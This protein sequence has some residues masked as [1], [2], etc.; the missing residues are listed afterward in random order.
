MDT[1]KQITYWATDAARQCGAPIEDTTTFALQLLAW[2]RISESDERAQDGKLYGTYK[3]SLDASPRECFDALINA[4]GEMGSQD[5]A[6][7]L[8]PSAWAHP[9]LQQLMIKLGS[10]PLEDFGNSHLLASACAQLGNSRWEHNTPAEVVS[11][12]SLLAGDLSQKA[13]YCPFDESLQ[14][15]TACEQQGADVFCELTRITPL[16]AVLV[17]LCNSTFE[18]RFGNPILQPNYREAHGLKKFNAAV[19][20]PPWG[21]S[22]AQHH[23]NDPFR[24]FQGDE[25]TIEHQVLRHLLA[26]VDGLIVMIVPPNFLF[27]TQMGLRNIRKELV[28]TKQLNAVITLPTGLFQNT[29]VASSIL[30]INTRGGCESTLLINA[31][32][33]RYNARDGRSRSVLE[34]WRVLHQDY[35]SAI[36]GEKIDTGRLVAQDEIAKNDYQLQVNRYLQSEAIERAYNFLR[37]ANTQKLG[38]LVKVLRPAPL[39]R[40]EGDGELAEE[41]SVSDFPIAGLLRRASKQVT[42]VSRGNQDD[43]FLQPNDILIVTKGALGILGK[44][45]LVG[46]DASGQ[47][48]VANQLSLILRVESDRVSPQYLYRYLQSDLA[49]VQVHNLNLGSTI[50]NLRPADLKAILVPL[51]SLEEQA[52]VN[53]N[54]E[55]IVAL[56]AR[57]E[58]LS[59]E[60]QGL[61]SDTPWPR[62]SSDS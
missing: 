33:P 15:S 49:R 52:C 28:S 7:P 29:S 25:K 5:S 50:P 56:Q 62:I 18:Y 54:F 46:C 39:S 22:A 27:G 42:T 10:I 58:A 11:L 36:A 45:A 57:I 23:L 47:H 30:V 43:L 60:L 3:P 4:I 31:D 53:R 32:S 61:V 1:L 13:I 55:E 21:P 41:V 35:V 19:V 24:R 16:P 8:T 20:N 12:M 17:H 26:Q 51:P 14:F 6:P 2:R 34:N 44:A 9:A 40:E 38:D 59:T 48:W 37:S